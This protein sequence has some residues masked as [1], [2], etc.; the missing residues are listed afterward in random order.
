MLNLIFLIFI[1]FITVSI[2]NITN[3]VVSLPKVTFLRI[4]TSFF[5]PFVFYSLVKGKIKI[6]K[7][8]FP[9]ILFLLVVIFKTVFSIY[10]KGSFYGYYKFYFQS[11][12]S[13]FCLTTIYFSAKNIISEDEVFKFLKYFKVILFITVF[14]G[15]IQYL[16][17]DPFPWKGNPYPRVWSFFGNPDFFASYIGLF[18]PM[19]FSGILIESKKTEKFLNIVFFILVF[20]SLLLTKSRA[21]WV[22]SF[23]GI[24]FFIFLQE[25]RKDILKKSMFI[26]ILSLVSAYIFSPGEFKSIIKRGVSIFDLKEEN[27]KLRFIGY[28]AAIDM[29]KKNITFGT[30]MDSYL[31]RFRRYVPEEFVKNER[32]MSHAGYAHNQFLQF[33]VDTGIIGLGAYIFLFFSFIYLGV[34]KISLFKGNRRV[35]YSS[36]IAG[37]FSTFISGFFNFFPVVVWFYIYLFFALIIMKE[38]K[39]EYRKEFFIFSIPFIILSLFPFKADIYFK[40]GVV[41][42]NEKFLEKAVR[43]NPFVDFYK[44]T[45]G[46]IYV[47]NGR[48]DEAISLFKEI[49]KSNPNNALAYNGLG[50]AL[51]SKGNYKEAIKFFKKAL[52]IDPFLVASYINMAL[53]YEKLKDFNRA[54]KYYRKALK[55]DKEN[56]LALFNIGSIYGNLKEYNKAKFYW[57]KLYK[58][59]S[60]YPKLKRYLQIVND[61]IKSKNEKSIRP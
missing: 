25:K 28:R 48:I 10:S 52:K 44:I 24:L 2:T 7:G 36:I 9:V 13:F 4:L 12:L 8:D 3:D 60:D 30:G 42:D 21:V 34:K 32:I 5:L 56:K 6:R 17:L 14:Y 40:K 45:L 15:I 19:I 57:E 38:E 47:E 50:Y 46:K 55:I 37:L 39:L 59:N 54:I 11:F 23:F 29:T 61:L 31:W 26:V 41:Y 53:S 22:G 20:F 18:F 51:R 33:L 58:I 1:F 43:L 49:I 27:I 16:K 35:L